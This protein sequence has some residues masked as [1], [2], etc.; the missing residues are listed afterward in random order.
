[1]RDAVR[2]GA[3]DARRD[4]FSDGPADRL[5]DPCELVAQVHG[6]Q[7]KLRDGAIEGA[8]GSKTAPLAPDMLEAIKGAICAA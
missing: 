5:R 7:L 2:R 6:L 4:G 1:M 3:G 8:Y